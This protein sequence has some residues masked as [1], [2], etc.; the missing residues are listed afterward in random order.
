M[1]SREDK[2]RPEC[3]TCDKRLPT[4]RFFRH[5]TIDPTGTRQFGYEGNGFFCSLRCGFNWALVRQ[6]GYGRKKK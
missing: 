4:F 6:P 3:R 1:T 5:P 2:G